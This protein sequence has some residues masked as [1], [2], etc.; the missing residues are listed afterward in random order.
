MT[1]SKDN[2][3]QVLD[4]KDLPEEWKELLREQIAKDEEA[5]VDRSCQRAYQSDQD[6]DKRDAD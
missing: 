2:D 5:L 4:T 1:R 3:R 6:H